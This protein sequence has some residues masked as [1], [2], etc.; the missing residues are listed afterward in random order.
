MCVLTR[1]DPRLG[2]AHLPNM[3]QPDEFN[4]LVLESWPT[5]MGSSRT[6]LDLLGADQ[7]P[8][9]SSSWFRPESDRSPGSVGAVCPCVQPRAKR[10]QHH[11]AVCQRCATPPTG[12]R[13]AQCGSLGR[14]A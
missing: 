6:E 7:A 14:P 12:R 5:W 1:P 13:K 8:P 11:S 2:A 3:E 9:Y 4:R 10:G